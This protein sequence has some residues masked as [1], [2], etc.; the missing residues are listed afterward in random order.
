M[1]TVSR[2]IDFFT[3]ILGNI[4][5]WI[6]AL[7]VVVGA[8]NTF[9]RFFGRFIGTNLTSN[10]FIELQ[11]YLFSI[12]YFLAAGYVLKHNG[13]VRVDVLY[14]G[15]SPKRK[16]WVNLI[17]TTFLL[18]PFCAMITFFAWGVARTVVAYFGKLTRSEW[19]A[20]LPDQDDGGG[21]HGPSRHAGHI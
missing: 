6:V 15:F 3:E 20:T 16:A 21:G 4:A 9:G 10:M 12:T 7:T 19:L 13:H 11:W 2:G 17:G 5:L 1:L 8:W 14:D 18:F